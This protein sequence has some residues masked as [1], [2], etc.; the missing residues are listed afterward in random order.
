MIRR[1]YRD[2][3]G[4]IRCEQEPTTD[5]VDPTTNPRATRATMVLR[6]KANGHHRVGQSSVAEA[7][8]GTIAK[9]CEAM[10]TEETD[11]PLPFR[12]LRAARAPSA[13]SAGKQYCQG[14]SQA[15][16]QRATEGSFVN[17][18]G[19]AAQATWTEA[20]STAKCSATSRRQGTA[21]RVRLTKRQQVYNTY[22]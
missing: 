21:G 14:H 4:C 16:R 8:R 19:Y 10:Q 7:F 3:S 2:S 9:H 11:G 22:I 18:T 12:T 13:R 5:T 17:R 15:C 6:E 20:R 1:F